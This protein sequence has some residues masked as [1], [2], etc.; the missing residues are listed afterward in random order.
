[1][2]SHGTQGQEPFTG[3]GHVSDV[4][5]EP[6]R[7]E[8]HAQ[9]PKNVHITGRPTRTDCLT[10][11]AGDVGGG[12]VAVADANGVGLAGNAGRANVNVVAPGDGVPSLM[13][14][15]Y[16]VVAGYVQRERLET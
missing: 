1:M 2:E 7:G 9:L 13:T 3:S 14:D 11:D 4:G 6:A 12:M 10:R 8:I 5:L 16:V 15:G